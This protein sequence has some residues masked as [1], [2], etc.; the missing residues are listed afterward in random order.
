MR[1]RLPAEIIKDIDIAKKILLR[2]GCKEVY[3]FGSIIEGNFTEISD[4][5]IATVGLRKSKY[6]K[7]YG[8]LLEKLGRSIDLVCLDYDTD[9]S[10]K[11]KESGKFERVA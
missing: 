3:I 2:E 1:K 7:V 4:I 9:F 5:D 6:F 8:E 11:I 10:K